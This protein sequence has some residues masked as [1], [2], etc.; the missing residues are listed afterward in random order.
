MSFERG[1]WSNLLPAGASTK[2]CPAAAA[3]AAHVEPPPIVH[4]EAGG[5]RAVHDADVAAARRHRQPAP[6]TRRDAQPSRAT[7]LLR[8]GER[9]E[10][11]AFRAAHNRQQQQQ[12]PEPLSPHT[13]AD[14]TRRLLAER[15]EDQQ[16]PE[17]K[18]ELALEHA[19]QDRGG[20]Q[21]DQQHGP[22]GVALLA[23]Q[24]AH[25]QRRHQGRADGAALQ[26]EPGRSQQRLGGHA[27]RQ[28]TYQPT[29]G[30]P[31]REL[32]RRPRRPRQPHRALPDA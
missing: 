23:H 29:S 7:H 28:R 27:H 24:R 4:R 6:A 17:R 16:R 5:G 13:T 11:S 3:D 26:H 18:P 25:A 1:L 22:R 31:L 30:T 12:R 10:T 8:P 20:G 9:A 15:H 14:A 2:P 32:W 21:R 19:A